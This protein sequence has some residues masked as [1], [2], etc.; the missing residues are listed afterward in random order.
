[1]KLGSMEPALFCSGPMSTFSHDSHPMS[2]GR[3]VDELPRVQQE[4]KT[5]RYNERYNRCHMPNVTL[6]GSYNAQQM[7]QEIQRVARELYKEFS[8]MNE[9]FKEVNYELN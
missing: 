1:M 5:D 9:E 4:K 7:D 3:M 2:R 8:G 6:N